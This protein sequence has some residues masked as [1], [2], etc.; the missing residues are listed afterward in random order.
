[1]S[2]DALIGYTGF[3][4]GHLLRQY[5]FAATY[6]S[7]NIE[8]I[9]GESFDRIIC[10]GMPAAK[11]IANRDPVADRAVLDRLLGCLKQAQ[12][13]QVIVIS[14]VDVYPQTEGVD[15]TTPII[16]EQQQPYGHHRYLLECAVREHFPRVT[17]IRLPAL[18]G[19]GLKKNAI[20]DLMNNNETHKIQALGSFQ[21]YNL[22]RLGA[23][24]DRV[25]GSTV[26]LVNFAVPP[27][28]IQEIA[29]EAFGI[30]FTNDPGTPPAR[31][32]VRSVNAQAL[33]GREY[34]L[35]TREE[36]LADLKQFVEAER[37]G[38]QA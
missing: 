37:R 16:P 34:Y 18:F 38:G 15:E 35:A 20:Y 12:A 27:L 8:S 1:M 4:G 5:D 7:T 17:V 3:V 36:V 23:D 32:D 19:A 29:R 26:E 33:W 10:C 13:K 24:I 25:L 28:T 22:E 2:R 9:I 14:T 21:F 30:D 6:R 11:W 31:Y